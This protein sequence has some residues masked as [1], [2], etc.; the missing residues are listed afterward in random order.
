MQTC[1]HTDDDGGKDD[2]VLNLHPK[3]TRKVPRIRLA[4]INFIIRWAMI[5]MGCHW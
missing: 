4:R 2:D 3:A 5:I 1:E